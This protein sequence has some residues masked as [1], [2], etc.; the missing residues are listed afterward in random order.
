MPDHT[1][2]I[3]REQTDPDAW[4]I[5][6]DGVMGGRSRSRLMLTAGE[7]AVF[8]GHV[9]LENRG[10]FASVRSRPAMHPTA[11][12]TRLAV[13]LRGRA[14]LS[15]PST[16]GRRPRRRRVPGRDR[17]PRGEWMTVEIPYREFVPSFRGRVL[18]DVPPLVPAE[19]RQVGFMIADKRE[20]PFRLEVDR[21]EALE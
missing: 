21:V 12:T 7:P 8:E 17:H 11:G 19:I 3:F 1:L 15:A 13:R 14:D 16:D 18:R 10:G 6:N 20:G 4:I 9:S 5:V 2:F